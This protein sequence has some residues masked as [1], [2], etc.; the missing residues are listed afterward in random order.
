MRYRIGLD[1][2]T[3]SIGW[4]ILRLMPDDT[5]RQIV[6]LGVRL[7]P[8]GR[9]PK[10]KQ[11]L[12]VARRQARQMRRRRDR[13]L[14]RR[15]RFMGALVRHGLL[16]QDTNERR[17]LVILDPYEV[18][19]KGLDAP[20][21]LPHIG[22]ALFHLNQRRGFKSNRKVDKAAD[23]EAG[24]IKGAL[25]QTREVMEATGARTAGEWLWTRHKEKKPVRARLNGQGAKASYE[26]YVGRDQI[27]EEFDRLWEAQ[28]RFHGALLGDAARDE[29]RD[30]LLHQRELKPVIPGKCTFEPGDRRAPL[31]LPST[32]RFRIYQELNHLRIVGERYEDIPL[33]LAQ[34]DRLATDLL[35]GRKRT[36]EQ[37]ARALHLPSGTRFNLESDKRAELKGDATAA[38]LGK[39]DAF[40][41][42]WHH[43]SLVEQDT[44][45]ERLLE[46]PSE[47]A[48]VVELMEKWGLPEANADRAANTGLPEGYGRLGRTAL[49]KILPELVRDVVTYDTAVTAAGYASHSDLGGRLNLDELPYYGKV[50]ERHVAFERENPRN[51]VEEYGRLANPTVH[52]ALNQTHGLVNAIIRRY[53]KPEQIVVEV[54]RDL[55][56]GL[57]ARKR[58]EAQQ[59]ERQKDNERYR[60][61]L[62]ERGL[63]DNAENLKRLRLWEELN[64]GDPLNRCCIY[65]GDQIS[66]TRLFNDEVEIEHLLPFARTLDDS[67]SNQTLSLR[68]ANRFKGNRTPF[69]AFGASAGGYDW[70]TIRQ[71]AGH[72]PENKQWRFAENAMERFLEGQDFLAR[73]LNDTAYLSRVAKKY[74]ECLFPEDG[75]NH[76]W[77]TPGRLTS[78]LRGKW[79]LNRIL[80][81]ANRKDRTDHRHHAV[82]A[83]V[84]AV[85]DRSLLKQ[86]ADAA[87]RA[88]EA[89]LDRLIGEMPLPWGGYRREVK[90]A[91]ERILVSY[92]PDHGVEGGLHND[93]AYG[94]VAHNPKGPSQ[95]V[96]RVP[97]TA[98]GKPD[99]IELIRDTEIREELLG[100]LGQLQGKGFQ[101]ALAR[102]S[103]ETGVRRV[104]ILE[105][106]DV[107]PIQDRHGHAYKAYKGDSNYAIE[108][109]RDDKGRWRGDVI[110]TFEANQMARKGQFPLPKNAALNGKPLVMRLCKDDAILI[111]DKG[112][113]KIMRVAKFSQSGQIALAEH[114]EG[115]NL[116]ER[117]ADKADDFKYL[118]KNPGGLP[119]LKA[120]RAT[121][122]FLGI[123]RDPRFE[124]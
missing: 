84:I 100:R 15:E 66:I 102:W 83:A 13:Y 23:K 87:Q 123:L 76:V 52:I 12:A 14:K 3:N 89:K 48:M 38:A 9:N 11:S 124:P 92:K 93:T 20:L 27:A 51:E 103:E 39:D 104:R 109:W 79:G 35:R 106:L 64:R 71:R 54:T 36:F 113:R 94:I 81:D 108:I 1:L 105:S 74:L 86:V 78:L 50:L 40:G 34:R 96:H 97:I 37:M 57:E 110:T 91:V 55:K 44:I 88:T 111:E 120:R 56:K 18:R 116:K 115:G 95:V 25:R 21:P 16:P 42:R 53:G 101:A 70:E 28:R 61:V 68:R 58:I 112:Q 77:V 22:R 49:G 32:Q 10:D 45:V 63:P 8:D 107:I 98:L 73:Q 62:A 85:T 33:T 67:F 30:I 59:K 19:A 4:A 7:F 69:E 90:E 118:L 41:E 117:D 80:S 31:A 119:S 75:R 6:R 99:S 72:L 26:L 17:A 60:Q 122:D 24:K 2:G 121:V 43:L 5:P 29:L 65:T 114:H 82:D 47:T 46:E